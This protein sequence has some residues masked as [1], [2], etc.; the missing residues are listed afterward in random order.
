MPGKEQPE[1]QVKGQVMR[2]TR[3]QA[4]E[5]M[6]CLREFFPVVRLVDVGNPS[7]ESKTETEYLEEKTIHKTAQYVEVDG[8]PY[9]LEILQILET[10][11]VQRP[12]ENNDLYRD[13]LTGTYNRRFYEDQLRRKYLAAGIAMIDLDDFK[14]YNDMFGHHAG[15]VV[16]ETAVR[17]IRHCIRDT[18]YLIRYG[19]DE[20]LLI[21]PDIAGDDLARKL[22][23]INSKLHTTPV[24]GYNKLH[25][26]ASIG[27]VLSAGM[28]VEKAVCEADKLMYQAKQK[29][30]TVV[31]EYDG[32]SQ[33]E[34]KEKSNRPIILIV[35]DSE[36]NRDILR[37]ILH[38]EYQILE[39]ASGE[40]CLARLEEKGLGISLI[41]L[42]IVMPGMNG[43]EVL[44]EMERRNWTEDIPVIMIS[45]EDSNV[46]VRRSYELGASDYISR[47]FDARI[48]YRRVSNTIRLYA[49]QRRL[50]AM[51]AQQFYEREKN[52]RMMINIL[53]QV[54]ELRNGES[55]LHVQHIQILTGI[56]LE[57]VSQKTEKYH[58]T[59]SERSLI[60]MASALH[61]I[62]KIAID[63]AI[64]NKPGKY[65][66]E[67]FAIMK[68]HT[69]IGASMLEQLVQY[70]DDPLVQTARQICRWH[71][72]RYD[73]RG[74]PDGL[75]GDE[76]PIAAQVVSIADVY[77]ALTSER[78]YKKAIPHDEA[79]QMILRGECG[80]FHPLLIECLLDVQDRIQME[81]N[82]LG[83]DSSEHFLTGTGARIHIVTGDDER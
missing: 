22:R 53:S 62:G 24:P 25:L 58:L 71:H 74:Y 3:Q 2:M 6:E 76:I 83:T 51:V 54:V 38:E 18:D 82:T 34:G 17:T 61:D 66:P 28:T 40:E 33:D 78:V 77:D 50:S 31:T 7:K 27:G 75:L 42:D 56:L 81:L 64:L 35:D 70:K 29:K 26:S 59:A 80:A 63:D 39:V 20:L 16:L 15:D 68:T 9:I 32:P 12:N 14:L 69:V 5:K 60:A 44:S 49:K 1:E 45:S 11:D 72:E 67:E 23:M 43:L 37:E 79:I 55:G 8:K 57:R 41:L 21:F 13:A 10:E 4:E 30:N 36:L 46:V 65:T 52:S 48:V 19:G 47:P 73:G